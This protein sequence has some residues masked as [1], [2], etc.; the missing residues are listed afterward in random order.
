MFWAMAR[1]LPASFYLRDTE[2]VARE[3]LGKTLVHVLKNGDRV[4]GKIVETEAYIGAEDLA[5]HSSGGLRTPRTE[6]MFLPGGHAYVYL[7]YGM[8]YCF[9]VVTREKD[10]PQ[11]VLIRALEPLENIELMRRRRMVSRDKD[12]ANGPGK[13]CEALQID[14][15]QD[16]LSLR[17]KEI[18]IEDATSVSSKQIVATPRI[19]VDY[20]EHAAGW[21]LR[22]FIRESPFISGAKKQNVAGGSR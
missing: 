19:G 20:A 22:F 12:L 3:L 11:A 17:S 1:K 10:E 2:L 18:F 13:L 5:A 21:P 15:S 7:I 4:S 14:K 6:S 16:R 8:H 9:N